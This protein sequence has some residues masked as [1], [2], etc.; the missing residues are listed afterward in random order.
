VKTC[1]Y[2]DVICEHDCGATFQRRFK[3]KHVEKDCGKKII[4]CTYCDDRFLR[5]DKKVL[6]MY[7]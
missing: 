2:E 7:H 6:N 5:E 1:E 3:E 4:S